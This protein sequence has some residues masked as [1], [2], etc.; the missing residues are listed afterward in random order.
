MKISPKLKRELRSVPITEF[1]IEQQDD[2]RYFTGY[3]ALFNSLSQDLGGWKERIKPGAFSRALKN[4]AEVHN[5]INHN[6]SLIL[7]NTT[8]GT[9]EL[10]EDEKGLR[11]KTL[12]GSRSYEKDLIESMERGDISKCSFSFSAVEQQWIEESDPAKRGGK[13]TVRELG[14]LDLFDVS[15]VTSP[16]YTDTSAQVAFRSMFPDGVPDEV[17]S[18]MSVANGPTDCQCSCESCVAGTCSNCTNTDCEDENCEDCPQQEARDADTAQAARLSAVAAVLREEQLRSITFKPP[19]ASADGQGV[20]ELFIYGDIGE[21]WFSYGITAMGIK[22]QIANADPHAKIRV[23]INSFGGDAFE[24]IAINN[25]LKAQ[26]KPIEVCIDGIAASA[27][28]IIAMA[29]GTILMG[30]NC[31]MMVHNASTMAYGYAS[32][33]RKTAGVL[34]KVSEAVANTYV[35]RI[36]IPMAR[37]KA[38]MDAETWMTADE[39]I[40]DGFATGLIAEERMRSDDSQCQLAAVAG[41]SRAIHFYRNAPE[42]IKTIAQRFEEREERERLK[43]RVS[44]AAL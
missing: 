34:D 21:S 17:N 4:K 38:I 8:A 36:G 15:I 26:G 29:G 24:G 19:Q 3:A 11:F 13:Q 14:D 33:L 42:H 6:E 35:D 7:G 31:M 22:N 41:V 30:S 16:A 9:T 37:I 44:V 27:A 20:L 18:H 28:S 12:A 39:C 25:L 10:F 1:R 2:K 5:L 40:K 23:R 32:D 43:T